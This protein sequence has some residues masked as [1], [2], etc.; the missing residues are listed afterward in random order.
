MAH[1][2]ESKLSLRISG[3]SLV[4]AE[5]TKLL[6]GSATFSHA[7]GDEIH[8]KNTGQ[9]RV[10]RSGMWLLS[11]NDRSPENLDG[12]LREIFDQLTDNLDVW[13][14]ISASYSAD[15]FVGMFM[16]G[17][18]EGLTITASV[19]KMI[20]DRRLE[21]GFDVYAGDPETETRA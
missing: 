6:A 17:S 1:I 8:G 19:M 12:Q 3:D 15:L 11:V 18:N 14:E 5:I 21:I 7:K 9:S 10:A 4:P 2:H 20:A 13:Q 16:Q